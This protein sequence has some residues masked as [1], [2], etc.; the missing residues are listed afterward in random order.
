MEIQ[1]LWATKMTTVKWERRS[2]TPGRT[3]YGAS[4]AANWL[5]PMLWARH[6]NKAVPSGYR[7]TGIRP[8]W[9]ALPPRG[10]LPART[11]SGASKAPDWLA[12]AQWELQAQA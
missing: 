2:S 5:A 7:L 12:P 3:G 1:L 4:K 9:A 6:Q 8:L 10:C 11:E